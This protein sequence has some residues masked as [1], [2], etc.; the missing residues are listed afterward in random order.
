M[1]PILLLD[2]DATLFDTHKLF[3]DYIRQ[4]LLRLI[5]TSREDFE[6]TEKIYKATLTKA[7]D[8]DPVAFAHHF[9]SSHQV[10]TA[11]ILALFATEHWY[12][13]SVFPDVKQM[14]PRLSKQ[15]RLGL[16]SEGSNMYQRQKIDLGGISNWFDPALTFIFPRK[17]TP[18]A[19]NQLPATCI[20][21]DDKIEYLTTFSTSEHRMGIWINRASDEAHDDFAT[22]HSFLEIWDA[23]PLE[24]QI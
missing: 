4:A 11:S 9:A 10:E 15:Y 20:L 24:H 18:E 3:H 1:K 12:R 17:S 2:I 14:L 5:G 13:N 23:L 19:L 22:I 6:T 16:Y 8:F 21:V 7:T